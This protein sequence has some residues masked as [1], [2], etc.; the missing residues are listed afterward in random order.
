MNK[1]LNNRLR[2]IQENFEFS[3]L[4][5][6]GK[7]GI[8]VDE[9]SDFRSGNLGDDIKINLIS[10]FVEK[11]EANIYP[12]RIFSAMQRLLD[13]TFDDHA[14][15]VIGSV[16]GAGKTYA[17]ESY[18]NAKPDAVFIEIPE[19]ITPRYLLSMISMRLGLP[20]EGLNL[21]QMYENIKGSL[22]LNEKLLVFDEADRLNKKMSEI[23]RD[24][25]HDGKGNCGIAFIGDENM[26]NKIK[27]GESLKENL[28]RLLR[29]VKYVEIFKP[30]HPDDLKI[31]F[32]DILGR[33]KITEP[34]ILQAFEIFKNLGGLASIIDLAKVMKV[35]KEKKQNTP[36]DKMLKE[37]IERVK[38]K[39]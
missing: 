28:I 5:L 36:D 37:A 10:G 6:S 26:K 32:N 13:K 23:L 15:T 30:I 27:R 4:Q 7:I 33:N 16:S 35:F 39:F 9:L 21:M 22:A 25:W 24:I 14:I 34:A 31:V 29:R 1:E 18:C 2:K 20:W 17:G 3:D 19:V 38:T 8:T 12:T 11:L